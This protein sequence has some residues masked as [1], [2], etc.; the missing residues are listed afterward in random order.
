MKIS[1][2]FFFFVLAYAFFKHG[3]QLPEV[4][5][6]EEPT[7]EVKDKVSVVH[8]ENE[9]KVTVMMGDELFTAYIY[10]DDLEKPVLYPV[11]APGNIT[12][13]R[14]FPLEAKGGERADHPHHVGIW[15]NYGD[16]NGLDFWNNS[17]N[18]PEEKK[19]HYGSIRHQK[20]LNTRSGDQGVLQVSAD[21]LSPQGDKLL[22]EQTTFYFREEGGQRIIDRVVVLTAQDQKVNFHDNKEGMIAIR[23]TRALEFPSEKPVK[24]TDSEGKPMSEATLN[25]EG[26][27]GNYL[28]SEGVSGEQVWGT[29]A[30]WMKLYGN[31]D[32][33]PV[34]IA[35]IDH[36]QN[37]GYPTYWHARTY[38]LFAANPLGQEVFSEG[39]EK[40]DF[41]LDPGEDVTFRYRIIIA[42]GEKLTATQLNT[43]AKDFSQV[44]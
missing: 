11:N 24:L 23:V 8:H 21:W 18:I 2:T 35:I 12:L 26:V 36:P 15:M 44:L 43:L 25:N 17:Y 22:N 3:I 31:I 6:A 28:S 29:R 1:L 19:D 4:A 9:K 27:N 41:S 20:V 16:V 5:L 32:N 30:E 37:P 14:G 42:S 34:A 7:V 40:L 33:E 39:K 13:T 10:P 38:G